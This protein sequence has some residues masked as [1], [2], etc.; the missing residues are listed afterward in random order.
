MGIAAGRAGIAAVRLH[1][2]VGD[3]EL[4]GLAAR[5]KRFPNLRSLSLSG[6]KVTDAGLARLVGLGQL[7]TS[8]WMELASRRRGS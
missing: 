7:R 1:E 4:A 8:S 2:N 3:D 6:P 5:M